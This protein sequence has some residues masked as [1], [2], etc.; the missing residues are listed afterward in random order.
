MQ[1]AVAVQVAAGGG[2][3][4]VGLNVVGVFLHAS[5]RAGFARRALLIEPTL[6]SALLMPTK[7][8]FEQRF[9]G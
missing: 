3:P 6:Q 9:L 1:F 4:A 2:V 7:E 8:R 5:E